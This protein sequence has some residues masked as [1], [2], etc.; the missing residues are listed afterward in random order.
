M[1]KAHVRGVSSYSLA[2]SDIRGS[3][4]IFLIQISTFKVTEHRE[5]QSSPKL[6]GRMGFTA[7]FYSEGWIHLVSD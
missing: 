7:R 4:Y 3:L 5:S 2:V 1:F 6:L